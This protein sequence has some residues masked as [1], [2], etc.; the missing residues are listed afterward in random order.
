MLK[1]SRLLSL[2]VFGLV[3]LSL[4]LFLFASETGKAKIP[5][6]P[7]KKRG[8]RVYDSASRHLLDGITASIERDLKFLEEK[9]LVQAVV[10]IIDPTATG[11]I[12]P[13]E[14]CQRVTERWRIGEKVPNKKGAVLLV[15]PD[16]GWLFCTTDSLSWVFGDSQMGELI[17][18]VNERLQSGDVNGGVMEWVQRIISILK[19]ERVPLDRIRACLSP[20]SNPILPVFLLA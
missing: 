11:G 1:K 18:K 13:E 12:S 19:S 4:V 3:S 6:F 20:G 14:Y 2:L 8:Q 5:D 16:K 15:F 10:L 9:N 17:L 7:K